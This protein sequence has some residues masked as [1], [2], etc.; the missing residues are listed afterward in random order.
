MLS[1]PTSFTL[2][3]VST[4][5]ARVTNGP[6]TASYVSSDRAYEMLTTSNVTKGGRRR[7]TVSLRMNKVAADPLT[8]TMNGVFPVTVTVTVNQPVA[9]VTPAEV[10]AFCQDF[11]TG[12]RASS[13]ALL[14]K[15]VDGQL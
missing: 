4:P 8:P 15:I 11:L 6:T 14:T 12:V 3:T 1:D 2:A 5:L 9:G 7:S 10:L 13:D